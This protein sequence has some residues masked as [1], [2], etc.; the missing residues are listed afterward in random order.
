MKNPFIFGK[1]V[2]GDHFVNRKEE[3]NE[4]KSTLLSGQ[5]IILFSPRKMG[6]TSLIKETFRKTKGTTCIHIDLWKITSQ[7]S[8][9]R[10][11][12]N[13]IINQTYTSIEKLGHDLKDLFGSLR[14][15]IYVDIDGH[16]GIEFSRE[17]TTIALK[18]ALD[19]PE[20]VAMKK[21]TKLIIAFDE[22]QE[23]EHLNGLQLEK[24]FRSIL[25]H[26]EHVSY[27]FTGSEHSLIN[28]IFGEKERPFYRFA[29]HMEL[30]PIKNE[31]LKK[32]IMNKF[33]QSGKKIDPN[34]AQWI[35]NFSKGIPYYVQHMSHEVWYITKKEADIRTAKKCLEERILPPLATGFQAIWNRIKSDEQKRLLI[36][37][38]NEIDP[39]IYS[40]GFIKKYDLKSGGHVSM[41]VATRMC[42]YLGCISTRWIKR[43]NP[44]KSTH[45]HTT[46]VQ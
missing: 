36:G 15:K 33:T 38:A 3:I 2:V 17:E 35:T 26:H 46:L 5:H 12:I 44:R 43:S 14:P 8:L 9:A 40:Q 27:I 4:L 30:K 32:F 42:T 1:A 37:I 13:S 10:E 16:I 20:R 19:F 6:K 34:A 28:I 29:K 23:I 41:D 11:I 7:Y 45:I 18:E 22:F 39:Q 24:I 21:K 31:L 25:Q